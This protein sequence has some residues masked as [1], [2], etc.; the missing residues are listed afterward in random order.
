MT[1]TTL[2]DILH[3]RGLHQPTQRAFTFLIDGDVEHPVH[4]TYGEL[5][6]RAR[7]TAE[8]IRASVEPSHQPVLLLFHPGLEVVAA[9]F[10]CFYSGAIA[11]VPDFPRRRSSLSTIESIIDDAGVAVG[12]TA[13]LAEIETYLERSE[14]LKRLRW[15]SLEEII[16]SPLPTNADAPAIPPDSIA[17]LQYTSGSTGRPKGVMVSHGNIVHNSAIIKRRF[18]QTESSRTVFWVP[19]SHD[20][21]LVGG[22]FQPLYAGYPGTFMPP[23]SFMQRPARW[24]HAISALRATTSAAPNFAYD[25]CIR[26][27][28]PAQRDSLDL[29]TWVVAINGAE[30]IQAH[31]IERFSEFFAPCGF[32][33]DAFCPSYGLAEATL[34]VSGEKKDLPPTI[35]QIPTANHGREYS[36]LVGC[37]GAAQDHKV[38]IVDPELRLPCKPGEVGEI[39]LA[40]GSVAQGYWDRMEETE[41]AFGAYL[42][43]SGEGPFLRTGDLGCVFNEELFITGRLKDVIIV[44]GVNYSPYAIEQTVARCHPSLRP[45]CGAAFMVQAD[46]AE[47]LVVIH[48][49]ERSFLRTVAPQEVFNAIQ[50]AVAEEHGLEVQSI[51]LL[52]TASLPKTITGKTKRQTCREGYLNGSL[53]AVAHWSIDASGHV[54]AD[55]A[56]VEPIPSVGMCREQALRVWLVQ[57]LSQRLNVPAMEIDVRRPFAEYGFDSAAVVGLAGDLEDYLGREL[58]PTL[59]YDYPTIESLC[60]YLA[61]NAFPKEAGESGVR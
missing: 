28:T 14:K 54:G 49:L 11:V 24:L 13:R 43:N 9:L 53:N 50:H 36:V 41:A 21:G 6:E 2:V 52:R 55:N 35:G 8:C 32:Q 25:L 17:V 29:S 12:L 38:V 4:L 59:V 22:V 58:S 20:M 19:P 37:G 51:V 44:R 39:W 7:Q 56:S 48:E 31:T 5:D 34:V 18:L 61:E 45:S 27:T 47:R 23:L 33:R 42:S 3:W 15:L 57:K 26:K 10:G 46:R 30:P 60:L 16:R 1:F 40:G